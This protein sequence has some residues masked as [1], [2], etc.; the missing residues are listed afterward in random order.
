MG[1]IYVWKRIGEGFHHLPPFQLTAAVQLNHA[2]FSGPRPRVFIMLTC[3]VGQK[4][5]QIPS[6]WVVSAP[7]HLGPQLRSFQWLRVSPVGWSWNHLDI[8]VLKWLGED[9]LEAECS[10]AQSIHQS[11]SLW[12]L[13]EAWASS[14]HGGLVVAR[15]LPWSLGVL[16][17]S[18]GYLKTT[19]DRFCQ[20]LFVKAV[21][22]VSRFKIWGHGPHLSIG[23]VSYNLCIRIICA[24]EPPLPYSFFF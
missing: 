2:K 18:Q 19:E 9:D 4:Y 21:I 23:G 8:F 20:R 15:L 3:S 14:W 24:L 17:E 13:C 22:K 5:G 6:A 12:P 7:W 10:W 1:K 11:I 16:R